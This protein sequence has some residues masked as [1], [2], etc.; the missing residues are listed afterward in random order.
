[1]T[2][3]V[4]LAVVT[5]GHSFDVPAFHHL[6]Q[7]MDGISAYVQSMDDFA[8]SPKSVR[9]GYDAIVFYTMLQEGP[10]D[11]ALSWYAGTPLT[12][13]SELGEVEQ[14]IVALHHALLAYPHW[15]LWDELVGISDR[16]FDY[17]LDETVHSR[18]ADPDHP[19]TAGLG[20]WEMVD[21]VYL[22]EDA[23]EGSQVLITYDHP[24]SMTTIAWV[25]RHR[26]ARVFCYQAG[27]GSR[28]YSHRN[29]QEVLRR[30]ILWSA[31]RI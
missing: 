16:D 9:Q 2:D 27:H 22:M 7:R 23:S 11:K 13:L 28:A 18:I 20:P 5:G 12:A 25:R 6:F 26:N 29:F 24:R 17:S 15:P 4:R 8:S 14:G 10:A 21:E 1:M 31:G 19:I 30:G 3:P